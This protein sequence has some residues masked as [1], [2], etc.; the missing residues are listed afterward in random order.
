M[1]VQILD[2]WVEFFE[3]PFATPLVLSSGAITQIT[4]ARAAV[5]VEVNGREATGRG[6]IYLSDLWAWP[7]AKLDHGFRD[8]QMRK[9]CEGIAADLVG[10]CGGE[11]HHPLQLGLRLHESVSA[12]ADSP[13]ATLL[14]RA[15]CASPFDAAIHDAAGIALNRSAMSFYDQDAPIPSGDKY[16]AD[17]AIAAIR[18]T[19]RPAK[20]TLDAW[21]IVGTS[22]LLDESF[23]RS[24]T[25]GG[26]RCFKLKVR[27]K[28]N[29]EDV[30]RTIAVFDAARHA[31]IG[32]PRLSI[33]SNEGNADADS[34]R[35]YLVRLRSDRADVFAAVE[36]LEQPT[37]RDIRAHR[38]QWHDV[39]VMKAVLLDEGL[40]SLDLLPQARAD[41]WSGVALKT[42]KGHS[43]NLVAAAWAREH[44]MVL[45]MQ[46]LTNPGFAAIH[47]ALLAS[48]LDTI[49]GIELNSP[50]FTP[51]ANEEWLPRL[52][53]LFEVRD[54][55]H[56]LPDVEPVGLGSML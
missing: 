29:G 16:F 8:A 45:A 11:A 6:A 20:K 12:A 39:S 43:F 30:G 21:W 19:L 7:D 37:S 42:C 1:E 47:S 38:Y 53:G 23:A 27:G 22:D 5:R 40:T 44:G 15:V 4:E 56:R 17:G 32:K 14:A 54:G 10:L 50:Q 36:Y 46:D 49:N 52:S 13:V 48:R 33:D 9:L 3:R 18:R 24:V 28:D 35:D 2:A 51:A 26:F 34:V 41:G 31:G 55:V 25:R